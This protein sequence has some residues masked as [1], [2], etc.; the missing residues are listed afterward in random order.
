[1][2]S[3][4][5]IR[6]RLGTAL[7][8]LFLLLIAVA[9]I[10]AY[11]LRQ[12]DAGTNRLNTVYLPGTRMI[13]E[14]AE[15]A[16][17][18][19][20]I[21]AAYLLADTAEARRP[22]EQSLTHLRGQL[23]EAWRRYDLLP[24]TV[25]SRRA[26]DAAKA[27]WRAYTAFDERLLSLSRAGN[28]T[29]AEALYTGDM[30]ATAG[31]LREALD[32]LSELTQRRSNAAQA[33]GD[34]TYSQALWALGLLS[35]LAMALA[36]GAALW[37]DRG[38]A[39]P[40]G[41]LSARMRSLAAGDKQAPVPG[42]SQQGE[43][44]QMAQAL[45]SFRLAALEQDRLTAAEIEEAKKRAQRAQ[46]V[47]TL[48][49]DFE[50]EAADVLGAVSSAATELSATATGMTAT[51]QEG[52]AQA[53]TVATA[54]QQT[55][56][57]VQTV[58]ASTEELS[59]SIVEVARQVRETA[60]ITTRAAEAARQTDGTVRGLAEAATKIGD[61]VR[62]ISDIAA[63]TNLLALN[64]TIEAAR[65]GDAGKGFAVVASEVK[66]LAAQTAKATEEI[67][68]H[69]TA[70]QTETQRS[71][72]AIAG[73][74]RT[75]EELNTTTAQVAAASEQQAAATREIGR[76]VAEAAQ[77]AEE[78]S[79]SAAGVRDGAERTGHA[80]Q[81]LKGASAELAEQS[82]RMRGQVDRFLEDIRAA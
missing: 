17:R 62:L 45:E 7:G 21:Q 51:A 79:R 80:A 30:R 3:Q 31:R 8:A 49:K 70:M 56:A 67:A 65:A 33:A 76:A 44:G 82:E 19:R 26:N 47:D 24:D 77:G 50:T 54:S 2:L 27:A 48:V 13:G 68:Q 9:G 66:N 28:E 41:A 22:E 73:I 74:G 29:A 5:S 32:S 43:V 16:A 4:L 10:G 61:V 59:S 52:T 64:A 78:A 58:A 53:A 71:V 23:N 39:R 81:D 69:I 72:E 63:Q 14:I 55:S 75:V 11:G 1:M 25:E 40:L 20:Q 37:L 46:R 38:T 34:A 42:T 35:L 15:Y 36:L 12:V 60:S 18:Y 57:N 6:T